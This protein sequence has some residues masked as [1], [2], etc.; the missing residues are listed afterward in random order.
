MEKIRYFSKQR[1][2][3]RWISNHKDVLDQ[4]TKRENSLMKRYEKISPNLSRGVSKLIEFM[5][6][7]TKWNNNIMIINILICNNYIL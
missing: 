3:P 6:G 1:I 7:P 4:K 2:K 5:E